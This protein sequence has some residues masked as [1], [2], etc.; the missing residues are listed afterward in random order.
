MPEMTAW[1]LFRLLLGAGG[2]VFVGIAAAR[3]FEGHNWRAGVVLASVGTAAVFLIAPRGRWLD[4]GAL[5]LAAAGVS[6]LIMVLRVLA[7]QF[8]HGIAVTSA[9]GEL[10]RGLVYVLCVCLAV[11][12][13]AA[14][15]RYRDDDEPDV[16]QNRND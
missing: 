16:R 8:G 14:R 11:A 10:L 3:L 15:R 5:A 13:E 1:K 7:R 6:G 12:S 9:S 2:A 4:L